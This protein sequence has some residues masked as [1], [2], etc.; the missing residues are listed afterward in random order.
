[1]LGQHQFSKKSARNEAN[2]YRPIASLPPISKLIER[3][4]TNRLLSFYEQTNFFSKF[5]Y[6]FQ[7]G[8]STFH[9]LIQLT[10][11]IYNSLNRKNHLISVFI[12][13]TKAFD[14]VNHRI[15]LKK[16]EKKWY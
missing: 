2:N 3:F 7:K 8:K 16:L 13:L 11:Q 6:G 15:L 5:Q 14:T 10:E 1:M 12:D 4:I 9:S